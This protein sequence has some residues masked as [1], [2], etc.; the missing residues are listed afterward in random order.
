METRY[1]LYTVRLIS[2]SNN[3]CYALYMSCNEQ[4]LEKLKKFAEQLGDIIKYTENK[5]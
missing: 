5:R 1:K 4:Q 2:P 3:H